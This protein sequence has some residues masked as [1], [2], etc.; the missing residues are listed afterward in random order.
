MKNKMFDNIKLVIFDLDGT[1]IDSMWIWEN[2]DK[3]LIKK[4]KIDNNDSLKNVNDDEKNKILDNIVSGYKKLI[5]GKSLEECAVITQNFLNSKETAEEIAE[6]WYKQSKFY[7]KH[8]VPLKPGAFELL[9][10]LKKENFKIG[11][12]TSNNKEIVKIVLSRFKIFDL[13][14]HITTCEDVKL[15]KP[16]P[17]VYLKT[18]KALNIK[19]EECLV[20]EDVIAGIKGSKDANMK[21]CAVYDKNTPY[22]E[23]EKVVMADYYIKDFNQLL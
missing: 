4:Y 1:F 16:N 15:G 17:E 2:I 22:D 10:L 23:N 5:E 18:A 20:F 8:K 12:A 13:F 3:K 7:Y 19:P 9:N 6:L 21:V 11:M 14:D